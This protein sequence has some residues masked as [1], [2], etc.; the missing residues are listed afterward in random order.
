MIRTPLLTEDPEKLKTLPPADN[1]EWITPEDVAAV[2]LELLEKDEHTGGTILEVGINVRR[3][4]PFNDPGPPLG[5]GS[6]N[7]ELVEQQMWDGLKKQRS[8]L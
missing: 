2:M 3:V 5:A 6:V 8:K 7:I 4:E 1:A